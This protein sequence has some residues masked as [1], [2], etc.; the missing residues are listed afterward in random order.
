MSTM[1]IWGCDDGEDGDSDLFL[2]LFQKGRRTF[3]QK[4]LYDHDYHSLPSHRREG[5]SLE[6]KDLYDH[7]H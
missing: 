5:K 3:E 7:D 2:S 1:G 4:A 6:K